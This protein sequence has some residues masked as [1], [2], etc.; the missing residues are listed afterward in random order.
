M[1]TLIGINDDRFTQGLFK[2]EDNVI[3]F[4]VQ[5]LG[6]FGVHH[7]GQ[8][9]AGNIAGI[10]DNLAVN[11]LA[12]RLP[13]HKITLSFAVKAGF[14]K[15]SVEGLANPLAGHLNQAELRNR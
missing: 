4:T 3:F 10:L 6:N 8:T 11:I 12:N 2:G 15:H 9:F 7:Q 13:R 1:V 14:T 5:P